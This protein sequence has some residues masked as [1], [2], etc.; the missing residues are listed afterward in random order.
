MTALVVMAMARVDFR[1][2][3]SLRLELIHL[4]VLVVVWKRAGIPQGIEEHVYAP[5]S[6]VIT[7][8]LPVVALREINPCMV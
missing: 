8:L 6:C 1:R 3:L 5:F 2:G 7:T 4:I